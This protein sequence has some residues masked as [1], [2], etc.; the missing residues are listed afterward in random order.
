M[1]HLSLFIHCTDPIAYG[2]LLRLVVETLML[3]NKAEVENTF[4][5]PG[6]VEPQN[7]YPFPAVN[8]PAPPLVP[9]VLPIPMQ[10]ATYTM[11]PP[12]LATPNALIVT[13]PILGV[14]KF[15][16]PN[17]LT[18]A[19]NRVEG[20]FRSLTVTTTDNPTLSLGC[21]VEINKGDRGKLVFAKRSVGP[22]TCFRN[23]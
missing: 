18:N 17:D 4:N 11:P 22:F 19:M 12:V 20:Y 21:V 2:R 10:P 7:Y 13:L 15:K 9:V 16:D 14:Y 23:Y 3:N 8:M 1:R 6:Q 5:A